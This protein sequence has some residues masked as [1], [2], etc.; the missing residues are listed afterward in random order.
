MQGTP[1][2]RAVPVPLIEKL[3]IVLLKADKGAGLSVED[4]LLLQQELQQCPQVTV[5]E[6]PPEADEKKQAPP[7]RRRRSSKKP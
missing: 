2:F 1:E 4:N 5:T 6:G 3:V 7:K